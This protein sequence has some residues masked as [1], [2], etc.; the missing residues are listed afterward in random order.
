M[1]RTISAICTLAL[2][3]GISASCQKAIEQAQKNGSGSSRLT[4]TATIADKG[5]KVT[6]SEDASSHDLKPTWAVGDT[7]IGFDNASNTYAYKVASVD[8]TTGKAT[9]EIVTGSGAG[10]ATADPSDGAK[11]YMFY[12][13]GKKASDISGNSLTV[14][15]ASQG[16]DVVPAL[17]M[18]S[19]TVSGGSLSLSFTNKTAIIGIKNP[20]MAAAST[21]YTSIALSG[22]GINT[23]VK[24]AINSSD[25]L[26][27]NYQTAGTI[28]KAVN[29]TSGT[30][31]EVSGVT[32]IVACPLGT[33]ANLTFNTNNGEKFIKTGKT[34]AAANYYYMT[35]T[36]GKF[37]FT[38]DASNKDVE[39]AP[40]NLYAK[41]TSSELSDWTWGFYEKQY[42]FQSSSM[43]Q[44]ST[45]GGS[46]TAAATDTE[47]D[48][49]C[50]GYDA[51]NSI[52]PT[53]KNAGSFT[54]WGS[55]TGLPSAPYSE[56]WRT[57]SKAEWEWLLG[58]SSSPNP[59]TNCRTSSTVNGI[60][61]ARYLR[62]KVDDDTR[63]VYGLMIFPDTFTWP[64]GTDAPSAPTG[65]Y[66]NDNDL[67]WESVPGYTSS[68][69]EALEKAGVVFLPAAGYRNGTSVYNVGKRGYSWS[70]TAGSSIGA[71]ALYFSEGNVN[72]ADGNNRG[73]GRSVRL[74]SVVQ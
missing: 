24:F 33:G 72:P 61:N 17:M 10:S 64:T 40:G 19:A 69:F 60:S 11:M 22:T 44:I 36:F 30:G 71:Y 45:S 73:S 62:C 70:S 2:A 28:T 51:T 7:I 53:S 14:S 41:R 23:E 56:G 13:P 49:F 34:M 32:Y 38:V 8:N 37:H 63:D 1:K 35:P 39:F 31:K 42:Q 18:A 50:W 74:V 58:P 4:V 3:A 66:I 57:L 29:F 46:R 16:K 20:T 67:A 48:L 47:I 54:D 5:T 15:L 27:A 25:E 21:A 65:S 9:L 26:E 43:P 12:A 55:I 68:Q 59:G 6:Y 52:N